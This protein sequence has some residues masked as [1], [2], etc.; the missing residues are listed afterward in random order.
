MPSIEK[1]NFVVNNSINSGEYK[2][3]KNC[4]IYMAMPLTAAYL[5][6]KD[7]KNQNFA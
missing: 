3:N 4:I 6:Y 7:D 1:H 2:I 5:V